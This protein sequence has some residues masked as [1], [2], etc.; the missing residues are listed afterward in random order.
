[1]NQ[2]GLYAQDDFRVSSRLMLNLGLRWDV[3]TPQREHA[4]RE[5][6]GFDPSSSY[7]LG[8]ATAQ[9]SILFSGSGHETPFNTRYADFSP[10]V[11]VAYGI[12]SKLVVRGGYGISYLPMDAYRSGTGI[13][14]PGLNA[15]YAV[16]TPYVATVGGGLASYIPYQTGASTLA[17]P[18]PNGI[19]VPQGAAL[20]PSALVGTTITV[21]DRTYRPPYVQQFHF[22]LEYDLPFDTTLEASYV[23]SRTNDISISHNIDYLSLSNTQLGIANPSYLNAAVV[24][25]FYGASQLSGTTL[26]TST[27]TRNQSLLPYPQFTGVT[28]TATPIGY[29]SYDSLEVRMHKRMSQG[30]T[31]SWVYTFGKALESTTYLNPQ[32]THL[33]R[34][35]SS[36]DRPSNMDISA[37]YNLPVG[38]GQRFGGNFGSVL[39]RVAGNWQYNLGVVYLS[40]TPI[41][42]PTGAI[43]ERDPSLHGTQKSLAHY[44]DTCTQLTNGTRSNCSGDE[45]VTWL[46]LAPYQLAAS[47]VYAP[48]MRSPSTVRTNMSL[49]KTIPIRDRLQAEFRGNFFNAFNNKLYGSP[50]TTLTSALFGQV[51]TNTQVNTARTIE[52][53][54]RI[55]W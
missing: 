18:F 17:I 52:L 26:A 7:A 10:R 2:I 13:E 1:M 8:G 45:P 42:M 37:T 32:D 21:R 31:V 35:I 3:Q 48:N 15:G 25:P 9:G 28:E 41:L 24:N 6:V 44:I 50:N 55:M 23:G 46:Q 19:L 33:D 14:D 12:N 36:W 29:S 34:E 11:G 53:A 39:D 30:L 22:G 5:D 20:G 54:L 49:F 40:G 38:R 43:R 16:N 4:G 51:A 27:I 47:S